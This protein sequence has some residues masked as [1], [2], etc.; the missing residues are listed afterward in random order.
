MNK[1][2]LK[3]NKK[4]KSEKGTSLGEMLIVV[5]ILLLITSTLVT[6]MTLAE[7]HFVNSVRRSEAYDLYGNLQEVL[8]NELKFTTE[9]TLAGNHVE[10]FFSV[11]Y[12]VKHQ[13]TSL[14]ALDADGAETSGYGMLALGNGGEYNRLLSEGMYP[15]NLGAKADITYDAENKYFTVSLDVGYKG[16]SIES[17]VFDVKALNL[18]IINP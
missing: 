16:E 10:S 1:F 5:L 14:V 15:H 13:E 11:T 17:N 12:A 9:C 4:I 3:I 7:R 2:I 8:S 6:G 18:K